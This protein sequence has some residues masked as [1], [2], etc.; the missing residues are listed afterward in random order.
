[1]SPN[2]LS[3]REVVWITTAIVLALMPH[4]QRFPLILSLAFIGASL[5][6]ILGA[7]KRLPLPDREHIILWIGKQLVAVLAF[8]SVYIAY[9]GQL[10]RDAGIELLAALLGLKLLEMR[11]ERDYYVVTFLCYFLVVT[12]FFYSQT[13]PT[14]IYMLLVVIFATT[15]L[16]QFNTPREYQ[17]P[18]QM[19]SQAALMTLQAMPLMLAAFILFPR[20][21]GPLWGLP[22]DAFSAVS[23]LSNEM[24]VGQIARLGLSDEIAFRVE[25]HG[26]EPRAEDL[27]WRGPVLWNTDG[28]RW[29]AGTVGDGPATPVERREDNYHYTLTLEPH[30][31][32]WLMGL[33][34]VTSI[35]TGVRHT[36]DHRLLASR[37]VRR[38]IRYDLHST[39]DYRIGEITAEQRH[40]A[41]RLPPGWHLRARELAVGW[42]QTTR[43]QRELVDTALAFFRDNDFYYSLTPPLLPRDAVDDFIFDTR[44]GFCEHFA[45]AFVV[46]MRA[47]G[48]PARVV[49]G[50]Q[51]GDYNSVGEYLVVRQRDAH[52]WAEV[53]LSGR[54]WLRVDPTAAVAPER[55]S[56][57][58]TDLLPRD[59]PLSS[60]ARTAVAAAFWEQLRDSWDAV[61]YGWN[62]WVLGY[63]PQRQ[64]RLLD[65]LGL[66]EWDYG[67]LVIAL[68]L[69]LAAVT[70]ALSLLLLR[71]SHL[72]TDPALRAYIRFCKKLNRA[73]LVRDPSEAPVAFARR[74]MHERADLSA[75]VFAITRLYTQIRYG[76]VVIDPG[77][78]AARVQKFKPARRA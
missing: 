27:Y 60:F 32:R 41:L 24:T 34:M 58:I 18:H 52:A 50:Y 37:P 1:M 65:D 39:V 68:T 53:Y 29:T 3:T 57:G 15:V 69:L 61:T 12:N 19:F 14:A 40:A 77:R 51:G 74:V 62:Q 21:P 7:M 45:S 10:G 43:D 11:G 73:G 44:E 46:L 54:G 66:E 70:I 8:V 71:S 35:G 2:V 23:G 56:L 78:L 48:I 76:R 22:Q 67:N 47:A 38:R 72:V 30:G 59:S 20:L 42:T 28:R 36:S 4:M 16:I 9:H 13:M 26:P 33:E 17:R 75:E 64:R 63:S 55:V 49:T 31:N 25:F 5:W 6:R